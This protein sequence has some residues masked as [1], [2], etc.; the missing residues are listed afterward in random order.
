MSFYC[1]VRQTLHGLEAISPQP[2][3]M[4]LIYSISTHQADKAI[5]MFHVLIENI[6]CWLCSDDHLIFFKLMILLTEMA[7][8]LQQNSRHVLILWHIINI[9]VPKYEKYLKG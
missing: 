7:L 9:L 4:D 3:S 6:E 5:F 8:D 1:G 2:N